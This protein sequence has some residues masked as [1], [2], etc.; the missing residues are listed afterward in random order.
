MQ[1]NKLPMG[2][3]SNMYIYDSMLP[4]TTTLPV[5]WLFYWPILHFNIVHFIALF[6]FRTT[7]ESLYLTLGVQKQSTQEE[8][9]KTYRKL[10]LKYH[11]D[12]NPNN[13]EAADKVRC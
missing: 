13:P 11:P 9:K 4:E 10:A 3:V 12:K 7:G 6:F 5:S 8:I 2:L 1:I